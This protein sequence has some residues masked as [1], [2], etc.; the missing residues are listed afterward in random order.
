M[1]VAIGAGACEILSMFASIVGA[2]AVMGG[3]EGP[4]S[5]PGV[6]AAEVG[7]AAVNAGA[8]VGGCAKPPSGPGVG[9]AAMGTAALDAAEWGAI[10]VRLPSGAAAG[11]M[12]SLGMGSRAAGADVGAAGE[13]EGR[14][15]GAGPAEHN[16]RNDSPLQW[17][18][19][20][21]LI[22]HQ[23]SGSQE[24]LENW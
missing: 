1:S 19:I 6:G 3:F 20:R 8:V 4:S 13:A 16:N 22:W 23:A 21:H 11:L 2:G 5:G 10:A 12:G 18:F 14:T 17:T 9:A 15:A 24:A 7:A